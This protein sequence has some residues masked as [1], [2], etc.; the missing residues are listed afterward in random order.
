MAA[1]SL[2]KEEDLIS[3][4]IVMVMY[5]E[6]LSVLLRSIVSILLNTPMTSL[7]EILIVDDK[8]SKCRNH[9]TDTHQFLLFSANKAV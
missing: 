8:S 7:Q 5:N 6:E 9:F 4:S 1:R 3:S 2:T